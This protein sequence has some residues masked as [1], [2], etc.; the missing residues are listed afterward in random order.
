MEGHTFFCPHCGALYSMTRSQLADS[1][2]KTAKC[3]VCSKIMDRW[4]TTD[5]PIFKLIHDLMMLT[6]FASEEP[7][8]RRGR[9]I[10]SN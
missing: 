5:V 9:C 4:D 6:V 10:C 1:E 7:D 8:R 2:S 3:V